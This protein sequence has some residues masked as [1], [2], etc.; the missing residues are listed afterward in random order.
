MTDPA[1]G[2]STC[3][4]GSHVW[5]GNIGTLM[6]K[7]RKKDQKTHCCKPRG[8]VSFINSAISNVYLPNWLA[9]RKYSVRMPSSLSTEPARV[10]KK[11]LMAAE[12]LRGPPHTAMM[13]Y[14]GTSTSSQH[15]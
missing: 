8:R 11:K 9:Y 6:A 12:R 10:Y 13:K 7:P 1:V 2:A 14:M 5:K 15:T 3:A 4:S